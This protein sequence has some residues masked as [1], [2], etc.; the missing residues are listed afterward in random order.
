V[1]LH[2]LLVVEQKVRFLADVA[3]LVL[4][5]LRFPAITTLSCTTGFYDYNKLQLT[6]YDKLQLGFYNSHRL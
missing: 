3:A 2:H 5:L 1:F 6:I 4:F